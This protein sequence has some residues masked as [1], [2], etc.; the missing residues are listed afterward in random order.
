MKPENQPK[1]KSASREYDDYQAT[2]IQRR[3]EREI[4]KEKRRQ[5]AHKAVGL[6][7]DAQN[8]KIP[9]P[10]L[11]TKYRE[12]SKAAGLPEQRERSRVLYVDD[13]PKAKKAK[14]LKNAAKSGIINV[15]AVSGALSPE[16]DRTRAH[17]EQ[18]YQSVRAMT[19]NVECFL[20]HTGYSLDVIQRI[21]NFIFV[22]VH[23]LGDGKVSR[24][25]AS[26]ETAQ[27]WK[28]LIDWKDI[29]PHDI[30]LLQR[31]IMEKE[32][33]DAAHT[34]TSRKFNYAEKAY[35]YYYG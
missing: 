29:Q 24:F 4:R 23:D 19:T 9:L 32:L 12:F 31:R 26:F 16:S 30:T 13:A 28:L 5:T 3:I 22:D 1:I 35:K 34:L 8:S 33:M 10:Q 17:A 27:S 6:E 15:G 11:N 2:Q 20:A 7:E 21:K 18:Y 25:D 14:R